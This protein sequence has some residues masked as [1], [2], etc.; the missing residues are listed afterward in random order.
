MQTALLAERG[1]IRVT[2]ADAGK[3]LQGIV[4][5][6]VET[7]PPGE[8]RLGALLTPQGKILVDFLISAAPVE[9]GGGFYL[10]VPRTLVA[11]LLKR[12]TF[13][14][15]RAAVLLEDQSD[16]V[17]VTAIW[18]S[19]DVPDVGGLLARDT[20]HPDLGWRMTTVAPSPALAD[21]D[22]YDA[23]RIV[24]GI[25]Q[26]GRDFVYGDT[27]PHEA[28][29]DQ[30]GGVDFKKGCYIGQEVVSRMQH[31]GTARTRIVPVTFAS[32]PPEEGVEIVAGD[33]AI[34]TMGSAGGLT[35]PATG[36]GLA[37]VRLDRWDDALK[38]GTPV[39]AGG[40]ALALAKPDWAR[41]TWPG[42]G[43]E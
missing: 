12:L 35:S 41:F 7:L 43:G 40:I 28:D 1:L 19:E 13:Y 31:R 14:K 23:H 5:C 8:A 6:D 22:A 10:D 38:A 9:L 30:L 21:P 37:R 3:F 2:G 4:T 39:T 18:D 15:L 42:E 29:M 33:K 17:D 25:P 16:Q 34:G 27:F 32:H 24:L 20:R 36:R 26:G 11:D